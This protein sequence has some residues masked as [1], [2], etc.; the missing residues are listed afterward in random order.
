[1]KYQIPS[2]IAIVVSIIFSLNAEAAL[3]Q[4]ALAPS[5]IGISAQQLL[6]SAANP[7]FSAP[8]SGNR[9]AAMNTPGSHFYFGVHLGTNTDIFADIVNPTTFW[10]RYTLDPSSNTYKSYTPSFG[11]LP[12]VYNTPVTG[13]LWLSFNTVAQNFNAYTEQLSQPDLFNYNSNP[14]ANFSVDNNHSTLNT[15]IDGRTGEPTYQR[16]PGA[17]ANLLSLNLGCVECSVLTQLNLS[18]LEL[19]WN[20][21]GYGLYTSANG[22]DQILTSADSY[23]DYTHSYT[24]NIAPVPIPAAAWLFGSGLA[25]IAA[26]RR[27]QAKPI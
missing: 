12:D 19:R 24:L 13:A 10:V 20:G 26:A 16:L 4:S 23:Q 6:N 3:V 11:G 17:N 2:A 7:L 8:D 22:F 21:T 9:P 1:M 27:R 18:F 25:G 15:L 5:T 14:I